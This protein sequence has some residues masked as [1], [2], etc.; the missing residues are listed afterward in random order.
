MYGQFKLALDKQLTGVQADRADRADRAQDTFLPLRLS[1]NAPRETQ[2]LHL[3]VIF[4]FV[5]KQ[6]SAFSFE[7]SLRQPTSFSFQTFSLV[8]GPR[9]SPSPAQA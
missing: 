9:P 6:L 7:P 2:L 5:L 1:F 8:Q 4:V 3:I